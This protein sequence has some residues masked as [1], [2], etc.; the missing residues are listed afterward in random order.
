MCGERGWSGDCW[1][2]WWEGRKSYSQA[3]WWIHW[4]W[5]SLGDPKLSPGLL[6]YA[7]QLEL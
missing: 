5:A 6:T 3:G 7:L 2:S 1:I 4:Q